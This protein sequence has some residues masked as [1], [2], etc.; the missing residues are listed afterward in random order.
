MTCPQN[1]KC[2]PEWAAKRS[3][4]LRSPGVLR[5]IILSCLILALLA[6]PASADNGM[7]TSAP[8]PAIT[9]AVVH[10]GVYVVDLKAFSVEEG[11]YTTNFYL[12]LVSDSNVS[13]DDFEIMNGHITSIDT[14][15]DTPHEKNY[16]IF[17]TMTADPDLRL[18]PFDKHTLPII[19]EPKVFT[20]K[21]M[22]F[23]IDG[24][25]SGLDTD[26]NLPGWELTG[27]NAIITN[28]TYVAGEVPYSRAVFSCGLARDAAS[29]ILKFFLP[30]S[31]IIIVSLTSLLMKVSSR[32]GLN[33]SM[34]LAA[35]LIHWRI[36]DAIP[37][38][39][40]ATF[41]DFFMIITYTTLVMVLV[42]G[43]LILKFTEDKNTNRVEQVNRWSLRIIPALSISLYFLLFLSIA[44]G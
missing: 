5:G 11:T 20:E 26:A 39:A 25:N 22:I 34:F 27:T 36:A 19:I 8:S 23:V 31:L 1:M 18:Y 21:D 33:G 24:N 40:Y 4:D 2:T 42:S 14:I 30:I 44:I 32:L 7:N 37:L 28:K 38:V 43:I 35:V 13:I 16:R 6:I 15:T 41:L 9:P 17:A 29:T 10:I 12:N 3:Y